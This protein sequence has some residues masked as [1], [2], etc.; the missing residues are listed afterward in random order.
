MQF[1]KQQIIEMSKGL[2][3]GE[4]NA[5]L[6]SSQMLMIDEINNIASEGGKYN[7]GVLEA[8]LKILPDP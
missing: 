2:F 8:N 4:G 7:K 3:F 5:Q 6:P 1:S